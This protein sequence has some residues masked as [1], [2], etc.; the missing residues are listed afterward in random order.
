MIVIL[1]QCHQS[2]IRMWIFRSNE[3][4]KQ[5]SSPCG[6][7]SNHFF[8]YFFTLRFLT[9]Y[10]LLKSKYVILFTLFTIKYPRQTLQGNLKHRHSIILMIRT[11]LCHRNRLTE[12]PYS[13]VISFFVSYYRVHI[14]GR[15]TNL[16][17]VKP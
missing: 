1:V 14:Q 13:D 17:Y 8:I 5:N 12:I 9:D 16:S 4:K 2:S 7:E 6:L 15:S 10:F 3:I 11:K